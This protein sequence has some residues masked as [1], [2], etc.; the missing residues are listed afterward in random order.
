[1][2]LTGSISLS[3][4]LLAFIENGHW[5]RAINCGAIGGLFVGAA[6]PLAHL[7]L[8]KRPPTA[9]FAASVGKDLAGIAAFVGVALG[10]VIGSLLAPRPE[11]L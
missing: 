4:R 5:K 10:M 1:M 2:L 7:T 11:T 8:E 9:A 3:S 6:V